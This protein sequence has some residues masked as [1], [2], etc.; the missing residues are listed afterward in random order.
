M[1]YKWTMQSASD[2]KKHFVR[3]FKS[4]D[5]H[6][7]FEGSVGFGPG[8]IHSLVGFLA[9]VCPPG[10]LEHVEL[11]LKDT[12]M[13]VSAPSIPGRTDDGSRS[14]ATDPAALRSTVERANEW[15]RQVSSGQP[16]GENSRLL[17]S[18]EAGVVMRSGSL[19]AGG[20]IWLAP[21]EAVEGLQLALRPIQFGRALRSQKVD[22]LGFALEMA[23]NHARTVAPLFR[24]T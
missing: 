24:S 16:A 17:T 21:P 11:V 13:R 7:I 12:V 3:R 10:S 6:S 1:R 19:V 18:T 14:I 2:W 4:P 8:A 5:G 15:L 20:L 9:E 23:M 22:D